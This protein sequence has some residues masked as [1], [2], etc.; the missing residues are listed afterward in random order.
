MPASHDACPGV[1]VACTALSLLC[2]PPV[3]QQPTE[4]GRKA[5]PSD[6]RHGADALLEYAHEAYD[7]DDDGAD[8]LHDDS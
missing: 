7:E 3:P 4:E 8:V 1:I 2:Y 5:A 6:H